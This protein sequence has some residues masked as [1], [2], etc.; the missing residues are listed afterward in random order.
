M[1]NVQQRAARAA[2][3]PLAV[4]EPAG[5]LRAEPPPRPAAGFGR[6]LAITLARFAWI[7]RVFAR[8]ALAL[9]TELGRSP[10]RRERL[11]GAVRLLCRGAAR[12]RRGAALSGP[13]RLRLLFEDLGGTFVKFGQ[14]LALQPDILP[15][16][17][18]NAL[19]K[20]LDRIEPFPSDV[21]ERIVEAELGRRPDEIFEGFER[22]PIATAS[23]GQVHVAWRDGAKVAVK[24]QR[25]GVELDFASDVRLMVACIGAIRR[26]RIRPLYWL[27]EP[28]TEF[29]AWSHEE[30]DYRHEARH[31]ERLRRYAEDN[32]IQ[33]VPRVFTE[34]TTRRVLVVEFLAGGTLLELLRA[35]D[36]GDEVR[37][38]RFAAAGFDQ[39]RF[40][41]NVI[42]N[43]LG[44]A[45]RH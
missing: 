27:I 22:T 21:A 18:C 5:R 42:A 23:V 29:V 15:L 17:Y 11:P 36:A 24:V 16:P 25:P 28:T 10:E 8:H 4:A 6:R 45:F 35:R 26:L 9:A 19:W 14:M 12:L 33:Y 39:D 13:E 41:A 40:A 2:S 32:P 31:S 3:E 1:Q 44:D 34:L 43:F 38:R 7:V 37:L 30:L 20:L